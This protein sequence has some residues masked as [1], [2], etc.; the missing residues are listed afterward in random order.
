MHFTVSHVTSY[1]YSAPIRLGPHRLRVAPRREAGRDIRF[2]IEVLPVPAMRVEE[3]DRW[4]NR[5]IA[6]DFAGETDHFR[7]ES[8]VSMLTEAPVM[9]T[10]ARPLAL[11]PLPWPAGAGRLDPALVPYLEA[12]D[13]GPEVR[14]FATALAAGAETPFGFLAALTETLFTRTDRHIRAEGYA[15]TAAETL[16]TGRGACRDLTELFIAAARTQGI[17]ARFVSGYQARSESPDGKRHLHAWPEV[18]LPGLGWRGFDPT[19][20]LPVSD[21]HVAVAV[22]PTQADT[23][24]I[25]GSFWGGAVKS[26][27]DYHIAIEAR[28]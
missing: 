22:A 23:M 13:P 17:P 21:G 14:R 27:L 3:V 1:H 8:K 19:H 12:P 4:G 20:G 7:I 16:A 15:K 10:Q 5:I 2:A 9:P 26:T 18:F 24:P 6:L 28:D 25:E 11:P